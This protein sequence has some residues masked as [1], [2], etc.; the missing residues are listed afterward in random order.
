MSGDKLFEYTR[1]N[2]AKAIQPFKKKQK[3]KK[4]EVQNHFHTTVF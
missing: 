3:P 2:F 4:P 1:L